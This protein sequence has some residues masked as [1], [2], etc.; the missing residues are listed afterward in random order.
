MVGVKEEKPSHSPVLPP[1]PFSP[2]LRQDLHKPEVKHLKALEGSRLGPRLSDL[3]PPPQQDNKIKQEPKTPIAPKKPQVCTTALA[4]APASVLIPCLPPGCEAKEHGVLGQPGSEVSVH[5]GVLGALLQRQLR[6]VPTCRPR[7]GGERATA[8][9]P[10]PAGPEGAGEAAVGRTR[11]KR[12]LPRF[13]F[14]L[15]P[16][17]LFL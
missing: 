1:S 6:T 16:L 3:A 8:E 15:T 14:S 9:G 10:E 12:T 11:M 13:R 17:L 7:E 4:R 2:T 5:A